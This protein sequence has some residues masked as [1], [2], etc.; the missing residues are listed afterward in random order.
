MLYDGLNHHEFARPGTTGRRIRDVFI[1]PVSGGRNRLWFDWGGDSLYIELPFQKGN[2]LDDTGAKYMP[3][4]V[5]ESSEID[6]GTASK[7]PKFIQDLTATTA[8]LNGSGIRIDVDYKVDD[9]TEW[10]NPAKSFLRSPEDTVRLRLANI[11]KF[12]YRLRGQ[13][14][15]QL[16]SPDIRGIVPSGFSRS[17]RLRILECEAKI[18]SFTVGGKKQ[19]AKDVINWLDEMSESPYL[20]HVNSKFEQLDDFD[21]ILHMPNAY[22]V[23]ANP[24]RDVVTFTLLVV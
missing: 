12:S 4:F 17:P 3:E 24:E 5:I 13:T 2:P 23:K 20:V 14:N 15:N 10:K 1:Q 21:A 6:M 18:Q 7:L 8:N 22:P 16:V 19:E 11:N 9:D